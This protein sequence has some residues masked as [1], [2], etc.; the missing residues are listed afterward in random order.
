MTT[1]VLVHGAFHWGWCW[2]KVVPLLRAANHEVFTPTL[3][4]LGERAHLLTPTTNLQTHAED[5]TAVLEYEDL[6][7]VVLAG[8][9]YGGMVITAVA[10]RVPE[11]SDRRIARNDRIAKMS[12]L[13]RE[14][15]L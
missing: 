6:S 1:F 8:H 3:T 11:R 5:I 2:K 12:L 14:L 13:S 4:G 7:G 10:E 15:F 9:S